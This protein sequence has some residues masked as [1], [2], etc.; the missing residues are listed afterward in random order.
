MDIHKKAI[1]KNQQVEFQEQEQKQREA[2][3]EF[4]YT[5]L[6]IKHLF[7]QASFYFRFYR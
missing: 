1:E 5:L 3:Y 4:V 7:T 6:R 2:P